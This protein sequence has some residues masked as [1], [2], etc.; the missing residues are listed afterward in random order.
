MFAIRD[1]CWIM[2]VVTNHARITMYCADSTPFVS[3]SYYLRIQLNLNPSIIMLCLFRSRIYSYFQEFRIYTVST[4]KCL[5]DVQRLEHMP[6]MAVTV[7]T[8][9]IVDCISNIWHLHQSRAK[10]ENIKLKKIMAALI[11]AMNGFFPWFKRKKLNSI[12]DLHL[13]N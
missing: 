7:M 4:C 10:K 11:W 1:C 3:D 5:Y 8:Y 9:C 12:Y 2:P 13:K 6:K